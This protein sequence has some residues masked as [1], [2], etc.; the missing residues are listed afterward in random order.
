MNKPD[1]DDPTLRDDTVARQSGG[2]PDSA[3]NPDAGASSPGAPGRADPTASEQDESQNTLHEKL[4]QLGSPA[5]EHDIAPP[6]WITV[7][8]IKQPTVSNTMEPGPAARDSTTQDAAEQEFE[9]SS[10]Y[11]EESQKTRR[12]VATSTE[13]SAGK[14]PS[15]IPSRVGQ[16]ETLEQIGE[17]AFGVVLKSLDRQLDRVVAVKLSKFQSG[18]KSAAR[19]FLAEARAAAQLRHP[20]IVPVYEFGRHEDGLYI[21]YQFVDGTTL[22]SEMKK[23]V[24]LGRA[25]ELM[26][27]IAEALDYAHQQQII[28][29]DI[30]PANILLDSNGRPQ[31]ADFGCAKLVV[32]D[33]T[34]TID[35]AI[36][37]TPAYMSPE[38]AAGR[39]NLADARSDIWSLG[40]LLFEMLSGQRPFTGG[41]AKILTDLQS[42][43][44]PRLRECLPGA[45][46]DLETIVEKCLQR[47]PE[48]RFGSAAEL[49]AELRRWRDKL[50][51]HS[52]RTSI[53]RR[54]WLWAA[55]NPRWASM[56]AAMT[57]LLM[58]MLAGSLLFSWQLHLKQRRLVEGQINSLLNS[59]PA[60]V[61]A[62]IDN[63]Q[64]LGNT[65]DQLQLALR[66]TELTPV[67]ATRLA[68]A[69][70]C[71]RDLDP[72]QEATLV[73]QFVRNVSYVGPGELAAITPLVPQQDFVLR[74]E[75][76][77]WLQLET[78]ELVGPGQVPLLAV[79]AELDPGDERW[80]TL[81][82]RWLRSVQDRPQMELGRWLGLMRPVRQRFRPQL[83]SQLEA[84]VGQQNSVGSAEVQ[85]LAW[86]TADDATYQFRLSTRLLDGDL[87]QLVAWCERPA[88]LLELLQA[89]PEAAAEL[90]AKQ[91]LLQHLLGDSR[92]LRKCLGPA[93]DLSVRTILVGSA[94][95]VP[96]DPVW[97]YQQLQQWRDRTQPAD[98]MQ[99]AALLQIWGSYSPGTIENRLGSTKP[100]E[101]LLE[102]F[103]GHPSCEVHSTADWLLRSWGQQAELESARLGLQQTGLQAG[104][105]WHEDECGL[106]FRIFEAVEEFE[107]GRR[108][109]TGN[110]RDVPFFHRRK[111]PRRFGIATTEVTFADFLAIEQARIDSLQ[112]RLAE[113][114]RGDSSGT[115]TEREEQRISLEKQIGYLGRLR[116]SR[117]AVASYRPAERIA[118]DEAAMYCEWLNR[119]W[120]RQPTYQTRYRP[121]RGQPQILAG[122]ALLQQTGFRLPT[123][124]EWEFAVR[125][126]TNTRYFFGQDDR[127]L[128]KYAWTIEN[129]RNHAH[130]VAMLLPS[131]A[132]L[133]DVHGNVAEWCH[134]SSIDY[135]ASG[136]DW[137]SV[138]WED[139][140]YVATEGNQ[141]PDLREFRDL[142]FAYPAQDLSVFG[143]S[144]RQQS[145]AAEGLGFRLARTY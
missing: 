122:D 114:N 69:S 13:E 53:V 112:Q 60:E 2:G 5:E 130:P 124:G 131:P 104:F 99:L 14:A 145:L 142:A 6:T 48:D 30:K 134:D 125:C 22:Q 102:I 46:R 16:Y 11:R 110:G 82:E 63:L 79:L 23:P 25:V 139:G 105:Q 8:E 50:P 118:W 58:S 90:V 24:P 61:P 34:R 68:L 70:L 39:A 41:F 72:D 66:Q 9:L 126:R 62:V 12:Q 133:F 74:L 85:V 87:P 129:S 59:V 37:G 98:S 29:R 73:D 40:V 78:A 127:W 89:E 20:Y 95:D 54:G 128:R 138:V 121:R 115:E 36:L 47:R 28:H 100:L 94:A 75:E 80:E 49:V 55:R 123:S 76:A 111:I 137:E 42:R 44:A 144:F 51:L 109:A 116:K 19:R 1:P 113:L 52:R 32:D 136:V 143:R 88:E 86:L 64:Q 43:P 27:P 4:G 71:M 38:V 56:W 15:S 107:M 7:D 57:L 83:I 117:K 120:S 103:S 93:A 106:C 10:K 140:R 119:T 31:V 81:G 17:G 96:I 18:A 26:I 65:A 35:G 92:L 67:Q 97:I 132:G 135:I 91:S 3:G 108:G 33:V 45:D 77:S 84:L 21:A 141:F 101:L